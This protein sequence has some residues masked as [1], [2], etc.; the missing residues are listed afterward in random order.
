M[1]LLFARCLAKKGLDLVLVARRR[2]LLIEL[3][4]ELR[5]EHGIQV[6]VEACDLRHASGCK[7]I[8][9]ILERPEVTTLVNNAGY[10][11]SGN[12]VTTEVE[13][14]C[15]QVELNVLALTRMSHAAARAFARRG[16]GGILNVSSLAGFL[17]VP[18]LA[19]YAATKAFVKSFTVALAEE[20]DGSGV[21]VAVLCPGF[22]DTGF[23]D[24]AGF[25][26][27][28]RKRSMDAATV[29]EY[30]LKRFEQG[31]KLI[32]PGVSNLLL[33]QL[34]RHLPLTLSSKVAGF[35]FRRQAL[36]K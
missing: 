27:E 24:V 19:V 23:F 28:L 2:D 32:V 20:L 3:A 34:G 16:N 17:P 30:A 22:T 29:V 8:E 9:E 10:G 26:D 18:G 15:G 1:G 7:R 25:S 14:S 35:V 36:G 11:I 6:E 5:Q 13:S 4:A 21:H 33:T 12:L 31:D